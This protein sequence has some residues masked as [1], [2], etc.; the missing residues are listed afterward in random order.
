MSLPSSF[1][2]P[3]VG[4]SRPERSDR[5]VVLPLP[6]FP[7]K[8]DEFAGVDGKGNSLDHLKITVFLAEAAAC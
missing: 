7:D 6:D 2:W 4:R 8:A 3:D 5:S 1:T